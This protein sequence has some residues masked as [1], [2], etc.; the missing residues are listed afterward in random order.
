MAEVFLVAWRRI[1]KVPA[2]DLARAWLYATALPN[3]CQPTP[4]TRRRVAL[5]DRLTANTVIDSPHTAMPSAEE[6]AVHEALAKLTDGDREVL[7]LIEWEGL[8]IVE[9]AE[10][11]GCR[12]VTARCRLYR[13]RRRFREAFEGRVDTESEAGKLNMK[14][15]PLWHLDGR[16]G[17]G[18][19]AHPHRS[20]TTR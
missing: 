13:A 18:F 12:V 20:E 11:L 19:E 14:S 17:E 1:Q 6:A 8:R 5:Q 16:S 7:L 4:V 15:P 10:V 2:G 9:L 3:S